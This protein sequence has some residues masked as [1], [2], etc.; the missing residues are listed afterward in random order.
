MLQEEELTSTFG[1]DCSDFLQR[2]KQ[3]ER[4]TYLHAT[5]IGILRYYIGQSCLQKYVT[6][7]LLCHVIVFFQEFSVTLFQR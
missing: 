4:V 1:D 5:G 2:C 6:N 3:V 7:Y